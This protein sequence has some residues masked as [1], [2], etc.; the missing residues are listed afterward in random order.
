MTDLQAT[1]ERSL[2]TEKRD[3]ESW[4]QLFDRLN[5]E[6]R[7]DMR[8]MIYTIAGILDEIDKP[9]KMPDWSMDFVSKE[10][11][12]KKKKLTAVKA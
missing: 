5:L 1:V 6:G 10:K 8:A 11:P 4:F 2:G 9:K 12:T 3:N 7:I